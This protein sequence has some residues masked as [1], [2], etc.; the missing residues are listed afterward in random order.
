MSTRV[1]E[2]INIRNLPEWIPFAAKYYSPR[3][4][5]AFDARANPR[6][7][8]GRAGRWEGLE[9]AVRRGAITL[10]DYAEA[11]LIVW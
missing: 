6:V 4:D 2:T 5:A 7:Y 11:K 8:L 3:K 1:R 10:G 9:E